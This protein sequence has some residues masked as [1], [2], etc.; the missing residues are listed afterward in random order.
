[1]SLRTGI[2]DTHPSTSC[3]CPPQETWG[4]TGKGR[5]WYPPKYVYGRHLGVGCVNSRKVGGVLSGDPKGNP[6][7][8]EYVPDPKRSSSL[9]L[10]R[11]PRVVHEPHSPSLNVPGPTSQHPVVPRVPEVHPCRGTRTSKE[12]DTSTRVD[13]LSRSPWGFRSRSCPRDP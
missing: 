3:S 8:Y 5:V 1:M 9:V 10:L 2:K 7:K 13:L 6:E 11:V 12:G 4:L